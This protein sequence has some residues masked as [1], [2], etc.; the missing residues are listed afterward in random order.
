MYL[1]Q[2]GFLKSLVF[3]SFGG[4]PVEL[5]RGELRLGIS[6]FISMRESPGPLACGRGRAHLQVEERFFKAG[7]IVVPTWES[8]SC[9]RYSV[10]RINH[11]SNPFKTSSKTS[12]GV[13]RLRLPVEKAW[14]TAV[15]NAATSVIGLRRDS[16]TV[17]GN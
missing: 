11:D 10:A 8:V 6:E 15:R 14:S 13:I 5:L 2:L 12:G 9:S 1:F 4:L 3:P 16:D 7:H 17:F